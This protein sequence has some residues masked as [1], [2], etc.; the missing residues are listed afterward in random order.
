MLWKLPLRR[1]PRESQS[2]IS[3]IHGESDAV[4]RRVALLDAEVLPAFV[5]HDTEAVREQLRHRRL[6]LAAIIVTG[7][8]AVLGALQASLGDQRWPGVAL[9]ATGAFAAFLANRQRSARPMRRYL[10]A[11]GRAEALRSLYFVF[12]ARST[13]PD[14]RELRSEVLSIDRPVT[15]S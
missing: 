3:D 9:G 2:L 15:A 11:R 12:L 14:L 4:R 10:V 6:Q 8:T 5:R 13:E 1:T 7:A